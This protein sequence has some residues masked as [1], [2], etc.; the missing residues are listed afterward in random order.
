MR[1]LFFNWAFADHGSAQDIFNYARVARAMGHEVVLYGRADGGIPFER[2]LDVRSADAAIFIFEYSTYVESLDAARLVAA[3]PRERR[4]VIDCD[5]G[6]NEA[7]RVAGDVNHPHAEASAR[8]IEVCDS[9]SDKVLQPT[10][11]PQRLNVG[12]FFFHAYNPDWEVPLDPAGKRYGMC[13]VGNNWYRWRALRRVLEA[14]EPVR[15]A[16]GRV[17]L[18]GHGWGSPPPWSSPTLIED[19]YSSDPDYL[20]RLEVEA[21]GPVPFDRVIECMGLGVF[22]PVIYRPLFDHLRL[23]TCRTFETPA[24][25]TIPL[26]CQK[27]EFV[28]EV[29]GEPGLELVLP[30]EVPHEKIAHVLERPEH[31]AGIVAEIRRHLAREHSYERQLQRLIEIVEA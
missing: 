13:Y 31:Y 20:R 22:M 10:L 7:I 14:I 8:W 21:R 12:S 28:A 1:L 25:N 9:L 29:Y 11:H 3:I 17:A 15:E 27:P 5:G 23:V 19:A 24:A 30:E 2:S 6:Y 18:V 4:V 16:V 26:F